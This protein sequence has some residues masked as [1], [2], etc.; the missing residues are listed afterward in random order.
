[1]NKISTKTISGFFTAFLV[2][3]LGFAATAQTVNIRTVDAGPYAPGST[4]TAL[5]TV[6]DDGGNISVRNNSF[7]LYLSDANGSFTNETKIGSY[8]GFYATFVNGILPS[9]LAPGTNYQLRIKTTQPV[10][11]S[12]P[13]SAFTI[14]AGIGVQAGTTSP[15]VINQSYPEIFGTCF[16]QDNYKFSFTNASSTGATATAT[17]YD[18]LNQTATSANNIPLSNIGYDFT[19][20]NSNYTIYVKAINNNIVGTKAYLLIN[21]NISNSFQTQNSSTICLQGNQN[22]TVSYSANLA[23]NGGLQTNFPGTLYTIDWGDESKTDLTFYQIKANNGVLT[24]SYGVSSCGSKN[25]QGQITNKFTISFTVSPPYCPD[26]SK[27]LSGDQAVLS[28]PKNIISGPNRACTGVPVTFFNTSYAGQITNPATGA[29]S[30]ENVSATYQWYVDG[31]AVGPSNVPVGAPFTYTFPRAGNYN[32]SLRLTSTQ[33]ACTAADASKAVCVT[34]APK[35]D[36][37]IPANVCLE[38]G[39]VTPVDK[40]VIMTNCPDMPIKYTWTVTPSDGVL[41]ANGTN[42]NSTTPQF[43]FTTP[44]VYNVVLQIDNSTCDPANSAPQTI[45]VSNAPVAVLSADFSLCGTGRTLKFDDDAN[46]QTYTKL[47]G[48]SNENE[49]TYHWQVTAADGNMQPVTFADGTAANS[50]YPHILF[51]SYGTYSVTVSQKNDCG[52]VTSNT[53]NITF[54]EAPTVHPGGDQTVCPA[55]NLTVQL[56]GSVDGSYNS[57]NWSTSGSGS[58]SN[59]SILNPIYTPSA[60]DKSA[61]NVKLTLTINTSL[62]GDCATINDYLTLTINPA[63]TGTSTTTKTI[64]TGNTVTYTP[65]SNVDGSIFT[66]T[67]TDHS[68]SVSGYTASG[69]GDINDL[70]TNSSSTTSGTV[71][72]QITPRAN[73]CDGTPFNLVVTVNPKPVLTVTGPANNTLCSGQPAGI[74]LASSVSSTQYTWTAV[75]NGSI[76]GAMSQTT[77]TS[78]TS[79]NDVLVNSSTTAGTVTY[80]ITPINTASA[81]NCAGSSETIT[82]TVQPATPDAAAGDD[83]VLCNQSTYQLAGNNVTTPFSGAWTLVSGQSGVTFDDASQPNTTVSGLRAG[84]V[85][86]FRWTINGVS[87]CGP[88]YDEVTVTVNPPISN[89]TI[90]LNDQTTCAGQTINITGSNPTG[91][92]GAYTYLWESS[93]D[94]ISWTPLSNQTNSNLIVQVTQSIYFRR[95]VNSATCTDDKSNVVRVNTL[96][97]ISNNIIT[98]DQTTICVNHTAGQLT[99]STPTGADGNF[100]YQWQ[101]STDGGATWANISG[102]T[103]LNYTT[104]VLI[105]SVQYRRIVST[106]VC[107]GEQSNISNII[108]ITVNPDAKA[109]VNWTTDVGCVPF[110]L[111]SQNIV[112]IDYPDRNG[113]YTW[114]ANG[115]QIGT[116]V[117]FPGYTIASDGQSVEIKLEVASKFGCEPAVFTHT[118]TTTKNVTA[119]FVPSVTKGCGSVTVQ[120]TNTSSPIGGATYH[121]DFGN[122]QTS[123]EVQPA[124]V[125]YTAGTDGKDVTYNVVL[126]AITTCG[127]NTT[128][129]QVITVKPAIPIARL[130]PSTTT[131]CA[132]LTF[133]VDNISPGT[134]TS[135]TYH[136]VNAS[137]ID[138]LTPIT[139]SDKSSQQITIPNSGNY[140]IYLEATSECATG[141]STPIA[142]QVSPRSLFPGLATAPNA[143]RTGCAPLTVSFQNTSQG[144]TSYVYDWNDGTKTSATDTN[145]YT[146]TFT[147]AGVYH[148]VLY[149]SN[150][151]SQNAPSDAITITVNA[152]PAP[153]FTIDNQNT[154]NKSNVTFTNNTPENTSTQSND[155]IYAWDF[156]DANATTDNPNT[157]TL[158]TPAAH[159]Y[160]Y[161]KSPYTV[162]LTATSRS[163]GCSSFTTQ[164][165]IVNAPALADFKAEPDSV[166]S[167]PNYEFTFKDLTKNNPVAWQWNFGDPKASASHPNTS[168]LQNPIHLY[169]DTGLYKVTLTAINKYCGTTKVRYVRINGVPGQLY[170]PNAFEPSSSMLELQTFKAKGSG[171]SAW[172]MRIFNNYGQL[173]WET[174]KL[175]SKGAP[176]EGWDGT[177]KGAAVPQGVYIWQIEAEFINGSSWKG[178]TYDNSSPKRTGAIHLIR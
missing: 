114:Y 60:A 16:P 136:V 85:Y 125:T 65:T 70:L 5:I 145:P 156:G 89:N 30:C 14:N 96:A 46:N 25:A 105:N 20:R 117:T 166:I 159:T 132:P 127:N 97:A 110:A 6:N 9:G 126:T 112:A 150:D 73:N 67:V 115:V 118:F 69:S 15:A 107:T 143:E 103:D 21:N 75:A 172:H 102:A 93:L 162:T 38:Q 84:Q 109:V 100:I 23:G 62:P 77:P 167:Y 121:W 138:V 56:N 63:N 146:H 8:S 2:C 82:I 31:V 22:A 116:G 10:T 26:Q 137:G 3:F 36:F 61:G 122:G 141:K 140:S 178:M 90:T 108:T 44:G 151:C 55:D 57:L 148:V 169:S 154:C 76:T 35:P 78:N 168:T 124:P 28:P 128:T 64:C 87:P 81:D 33:S 45:K 53:Q 106:V 54:K 18:D 94:N 37:T 131:G 175:D 129:P 171:L 86:T 13:S 104:P 135:Y 139:I 91:G 49:N 98:A 174:T 119:S 40:S 164:Q 39:V 161:T 58:F 59:S 155:L 133:T 99:G 71:T 92:S 29:T 165:V 170:V 12:S 50:K 4:I 173:I 79:I 32:V 142:I 72:Y 7:D 83:A 41:F 43:Q 111:T 42:A 158:R 11:T 66:W 149:A 130:S 157:S 27:T 123:N 34:D 47:T 163:T 147:T 113:L 80:T 144:A 134:N 176:M 17:F 48:T 120:F 177:Y 152:S 95:S 160:D 1:M 68:N 52:Q 24:H 88:K 74:T 101:S 51:S 19:A 153:A